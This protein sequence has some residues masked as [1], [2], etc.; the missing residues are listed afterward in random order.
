MKKVSFRNS[1]GQ[2]IAGVLHNPENKTNS[3]VI[4]THGSCSTK[5]RKRLIDAAESYSKE[6]ISALR[7]DFGGCGESY[8]DGITINGEVSDL[9]SAIKF[10]KDNGYQNIGLQGESLSGFVFSIAYTPEIKTMVLWAPFTENTDRLEEVLE[11]D[12]LNGAGLEEKGYVIKVKHG[13]DYKIPKQYFEE[14][15][16][17]NQKEMLSKIKSPILIIHG[18]A[19][20]CVPLEASREAIQYLPEGSKLEVIKGGSHT[21]DDKIEEVISLSANWFKEHLK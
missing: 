14:R 17:V 20:D 6:G 8:E 18:D 4:I 19:D 9:K 13:R 7:F 15:L 1:K 16:A 5:D 12:K 3:I 2:K 11:Q 21:L 10:V